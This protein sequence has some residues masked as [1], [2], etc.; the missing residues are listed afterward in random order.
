MS[1]YDIDYAQAGQQLLPPDKRFYE[2]SAWVKA[3][4]EPMQW[5][6]DLWLGSYK[7]GSTA[8]PYLNTTTY[9]KGDRVIYK[10]SVY[11][12]VINGN[13]GNN[14]LNIAYWTKVQ[15][16]FIGVD[17]RLQY[18]GNVLVLTY[19]LNKYFGTVFRQPNNVSDI[20]LTA[21]AKPTKVFEVGYTEA[22]SSRVYAN[23]SS[24]FVI[25]LYTFEAY[26][27]LSINVPLAFFNALD[28]DPNNREKIIR[29]FADLYIAAGIT[30]KV[31]TY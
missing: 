3:L 26:T 22:Q 17:E 20:Y 12:S 4:L 31:I 13:L 15:A 27:N 14:P 28:S 19:A 6:A 23:T 25:N 2:M 16:N 18:N 1:I 9:G 7:N 5:L 30:Y 21:N 24:E 11:E 10:Y 29:N 8:P